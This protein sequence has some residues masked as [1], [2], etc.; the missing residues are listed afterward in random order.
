MMNQ[1]IW[2]DVYDDWSFL[3]EPNWNLLY[4]YAGILAG[5]RQ[6]LT[7]KETCYHSKYDYGIDAERKHIACYLIWITYR[8]ILNCKTLEETIPYQNQETLKRFHLLGLIIQKRIY[9]GID[10]EID[11]RKAED[12]GMILEILYYRYN[13][14]EQMECFIRNTRNSRQAN[15]INTLNRYKDTIQTM[16]LQFPETRT[17]E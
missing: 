7:N 5:N 8:Y 4:T 15:C 14:I 2:C 16:G 13:F 11:F 17:I 3:D 10:K 9:V 6:Y 12:I 1:S